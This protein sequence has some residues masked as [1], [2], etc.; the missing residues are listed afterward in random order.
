MA[1]DE[2]ETADGSKQADGRRGRISSEYLQ[3]LKQITETQKRHQEENEED[4]DGDGKAVVEDEAMD[5]SDGSEGEEAEPPFEKA[6]GKQQLVDEE[7]ALMQ[8][9]MGFGSF[10][11]SKNKPHEV[12]IDGGVAKKT[13]RK[14]RQYM[15]RKGG[16]NRP[17]SPVF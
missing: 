14:Y 16:F 2:T 5:I 13:K 7:T 8:E 6:T 17:L 1:D 4:G 11:S 12:V 3:R 9:V 15:N 10:E